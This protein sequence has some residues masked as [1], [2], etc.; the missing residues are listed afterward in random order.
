MHMGVYRAAMSDAVCKLNGI[1]SPAGAVSVSSY[2]LNH[3]IKKVQAASISAVFGLLI[4]AEGKGDGPII[5]TELFPEHVSSSDPVAAALYGL[6]RD[7]ASVVPCDDRS[8]YVFHV[9]SNRIF[10]ELVAGLSG[11]DSSDRTYAILLATEHLWLTTYFAA[12]L[13]RSAHMFARVLERYSPSH[14]PPI[15]FVAGRLH[16][17]DFSDL[18]SAS[19]IILDMKYLNKSSAHSSIR[20]A[21]DAQK[22][23]QRFT[24][25]AGDSAGAELSALSDRYLVL[26]RQRFGEAFDPA[27]DPRHMLPHIYRS[28]RR[29]ILDWYVR[30]SAE[31]VRR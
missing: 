7:G 30:I 17:G 21:H 10:K 2:G 27:A 16:I 15:Y 19:G 14:S 18:S 24:D 4:R 12:S 29:I 31:L 11:S 23:L 28:M 25:I 22:A 9:V 1:S 6:Q 13:E 8:S 5:L 3:R 20:I 26:L